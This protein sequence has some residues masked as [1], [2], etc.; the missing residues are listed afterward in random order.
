MCPYL[1]L[2]ICPTV[3][4]PRVRLAVLGMIRVSGEQLGGYLVLWI[5]R[6]IQQDN[7]S[8]SGANYD[9]VQISLRPRG[10]QAVAVN[11]AFPASRNV[12]AVGCRF[13]RNEFERV[14]PGERSAYLD[15]SSTSTCT[16]RIVAIDVTLRYR[17]IL[18]KRVW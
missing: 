6:I 1:R 16:I 9:S 11:K 5:A 13:L 3:S 14:G 8:R 15:T 4:V 17:Q 10:L 18:P 12:H 7:I 2:L